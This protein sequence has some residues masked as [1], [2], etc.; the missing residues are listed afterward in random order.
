MNRKVLFGVVCLLAAMLM[1]VAGVSAVE[2]ISTD[3]KQQLPDPDGK[4]AD[5]TKKVQVFILM[6]QS[7]MLGFGSSGKLSIEAK[8][9]GKFAH[10]VDAT[11][12]WTERKDV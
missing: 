3:P 9:G 10:L 7:N 6:G 1:A 8:K 12:N 11:G 5:Q 4:P 2:K